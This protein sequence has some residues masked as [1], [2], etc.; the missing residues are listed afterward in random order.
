[1]IRRPP[2]STL[3]PYTTLFRSPLEEGLADRVVEVHRAGLGLLARVALGVGDVDR[4]D[5]AH[6]AAPGLARRSPAGVVA[7]DEPLELADARSF[8]RCGAA[9]GASGVAWGPR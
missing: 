3:F 1:M 5:H 8:S 9:D 4:H 2:R 7:T 6:L